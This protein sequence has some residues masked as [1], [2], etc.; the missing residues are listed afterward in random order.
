MNSSLW[1][2]VLVAGSLTL[3][4]TLGQYE[5]TEDVDPDTD[6]ALRLLNMIGKSRE[7]KVYH[8]TNEVRRPSNL[9]LS[10]SVCRSLPCPLPV[11]LSIWPCLSAFSLCL[12]LLLSMDLLDAF[13]RFL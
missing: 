4:V 1:L 11:C 9:P 5:E 13:V 12:S 10:H 6:D 3:T 2:L 7:P 8:T